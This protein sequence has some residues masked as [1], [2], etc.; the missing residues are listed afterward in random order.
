MRAFGVTASRLLFVAVM[1]VLVVLLVAYLVLS[2]GLQEEP[3][4]GPEA[5]SDVARVVIGVGLLILTYEAI[6]R[7]RARR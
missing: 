2:I 7:I 5:L 6:R 1:A 3:G 4:P